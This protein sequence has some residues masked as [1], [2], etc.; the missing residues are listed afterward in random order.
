MTGETHLPSQNSKTLKLDF[1]Y[2]LNQNKS[3]KLTVLTLLTGQGSQGGKKG[4]MG[5]RVRLFWVL[6]PLS[7]PPSPSLIEANP[8]LMGGGLVTLIPILS[9]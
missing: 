3:Q 5:G 1:D 8:L 4:K 2:V 7:L 9:L 6:T